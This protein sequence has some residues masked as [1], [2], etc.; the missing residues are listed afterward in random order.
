MFDILYPLQLRTLDWTDTRNFTNKL[1]LKDSRNFT[2]KFKI[3][4]LLVAITIHL[5]VNSSV[6]LL[7]NIYCYLKL[8]SKQF[9]LSYLFCIN[10]QIFSVPNYRY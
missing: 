6:K 2:T 9:S 4:Q 7:A 5:L 1:Y 10:K 8:L 3:I